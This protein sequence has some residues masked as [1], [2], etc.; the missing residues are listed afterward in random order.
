[1]ARLSFGN[2]SFPNV[3]AIAEAGGRSVFAAVCFFD[4][5]FEV[6]LFAFELLVFIV[7]IK[8]KTKN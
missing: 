3:C 6:I 8:T 5:D 1:M 4:K 2:K 7:K